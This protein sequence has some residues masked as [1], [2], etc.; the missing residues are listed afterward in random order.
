[1][2]ESCVPHFGLHWHA[3][4]T[5]SSIHPQPDL[6]H[7]LL[8]MPAA[9]AA[10]KTFNK[11]SFQECEFAIMTVFFPPSPAISV[12][13]SLDGIDDAVLDAILKAQGALSHFPTPPLTNET[14][15][16]AHQVYGDY[17]TE[18]F[19]IK[20]TPSMTESPV[21]APAQDPIAAALATEAA[22]DIEQDHEGTH[23]IH[24]ILTRAD[25]PL[26]LIAI[27]YNIIAGL[28]RKDLP[29]GTFDDCPNDLLIIAALSLAVSCHDDRPP[30]PF[31][32]SRQVADG[33]WTARR[34]D[35]TVLKVFR[36]LDW[37]IHTYGTPGAIAEAISAFSV[38]YKPSGRTIQVDSDMEYQIAL[39]AKQGLTVL[40]SNDTTTRWQHGQWTPEASRPGSA[41]GPLFADMPFLPLL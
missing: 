1:M 27:A 28:R 22:I 37:E 12:A 18:D 17:N 7:A 30:R 25:L 40:T 6:L 10:S 41:M 3:A 23:I 13:D 38:S 34:I 4:Q 33:Y 39:P 11:Y 5:T 15:V 24:N 36:L 8:L 20:S 2:Q 29:S 16:K 32:W 21:F 19:S 9:T 26:E 35:K 14:I 31:W